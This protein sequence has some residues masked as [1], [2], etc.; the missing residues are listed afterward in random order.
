LSGEKVWSTEK[1]GFLYESPFTAVWDGR[2]EKGTP[3]ATGIYFYVI[4]SGGKVLQRGKF[5]VVD[6]P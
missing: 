1:T 4:E 3:A 2:N 6:G 5:L